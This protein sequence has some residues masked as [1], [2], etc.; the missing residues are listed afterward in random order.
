MATTAVGFIL[1]NNQAALD[2]AT[3]TAIPYANQMEGKAASLLAG[4]G[5]GGTSYTKNSASATNKIIRLDA[6]VTDAAVLGYAKNGV[7]HVTTTG[8]TA[9]NIDLTN[10]ATNATSTSGDTTFATYNMLIFYNLSGLDGVAAA[11]MTVAPGASNGVSKFLSGTTPTLTLGSS[12]RV[13]FE[14]TAGV[15]VDS[16]HKIITVTPTAGGNFA[17]VVCGA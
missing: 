4:R 6:M 11:D 1:N 10:L 8:T 15:T 2:G 12:S 13:A 3:V 14:Y 5:P 9:V 7:F 17:V 16:T